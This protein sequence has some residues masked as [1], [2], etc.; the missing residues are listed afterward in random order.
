MVDGDECAACGTRASASCR[1]CGRPVCPDHERP[2]AHGCTGPGYAPPVPDRGA[3]ADRGV[4]PAR[5]LA[6]LAVTLVVAVLVAA[7]LSPVGPVAPSTAHQ[8]EPLDETQVER[9]VHRMVNDE[10]RARDRGPLAYGDTLARV[11]AAHSADMAREGYVGHGDEPL[12]E[13]YDR[14]GLECHGG[15]NVYAVTTLDGV[16][17]ERALARRTVD[18]WIDSEGHRENLLRERFDAHG[19][20]VAV[21]REDGRLTVYV[22]E[23]FC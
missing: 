8:P 16:Y 11:A 19:V 10:R 1:Y 2:G 17:S 5:V 12:A 9:L 3:D 6:V 7:A 4:D 22:T 20:G 23:N 15:E 21:A 14:F 18:A 13:R